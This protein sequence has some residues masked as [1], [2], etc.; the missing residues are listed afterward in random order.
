MH[1]LSFKSQILMINASSALA[2][3]W[4]CIRL[5]RIIF[6]LLA[7]TNLIC[8]VKMS[9][10]WMT[11]PEAIANVASSISLTAFISESRGFGMR[12]IDPV[13]RLVI[14]ISW[15]W[16]F[17][18]LCDI[19]KWSHRNFLPDGISFIVLTQI[20]VTVFQIFIDPSSL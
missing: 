19:S 15:S 14:F 3:K 8:F 1:F 16:S 11:L 6:A 7:S 18:S 17:R 4:L 12:L 9:Q 20:P 5:R 2:N 13:E 10:T